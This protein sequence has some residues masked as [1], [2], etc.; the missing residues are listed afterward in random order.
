MRLML[1]CYEIGISGRVV[2]SSSNSSNVVINPPARMGSE[3]YSNCFVIPNSVHPSVR[4][5]VPTFSAATRNKTANN[6]Y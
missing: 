6:R 4:L 2:F 3:G 1:K 5:S